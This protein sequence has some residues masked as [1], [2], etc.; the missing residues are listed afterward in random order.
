MRPE[1]IDVVRFRDDGIVPNSDNLTIIY[2]KA[3]DIAELEDEAS[4]QIDALVSPN[5]WQFS[6]AGSVFKRTHY[7]PN[8]HELLICFRCWAVLRLGGARFGKKFMLNAGDAVII[9]AGVGHHLVESPP[10]FRVF[11]LYPKGITY[12]T[13]WARPSLR[14]SALRKLARVPTPPA[15]PLYGKT[16]E[17]LLLWSQ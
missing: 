15:D 4:K 7:H 2:R 13:Y 8:T 9:P 10:N 3:V 5:G 16:G 12:E 17:M 14:R 1:K 11:G 6:W